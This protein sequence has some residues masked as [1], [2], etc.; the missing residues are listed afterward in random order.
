MSGIHETVLDILGEL[1]RLPNRPNTTK[2]NPVVYALLSTMAE[3]MV[4]DVVKVQDRAL[5]IEITT[6][7]REIIYDAFEM[8]QIVGANPN[9]FHHLCKVWGDMVKTQTEDYR[10]KLMGRLIDRMMGDNKHGA[11]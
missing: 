5:G 9:G 10:N 6:H 1:E 11:D 2:E 7:I 4:V 8:G 3:T